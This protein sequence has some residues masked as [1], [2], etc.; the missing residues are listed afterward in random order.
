MRVGV[1]PLRIGMALSG[2]ICQFVAKRFIRQQF[3]LLA[4]RLDL[5]ENGAVNMGK[6]LTFI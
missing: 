2:G 1:Y 3:S 5:A 4:Q 6:Q